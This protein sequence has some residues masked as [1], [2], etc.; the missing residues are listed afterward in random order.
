MKRLLRRYILTIFCLWVVTRVFPSA[1]QFETGLDTGLLLASLVIM[2]LDLILK[3]IINLILL[4]FNFLTLGAFRWVALVA[5]FWLADYLLPGF[6]INAFTIPAFTV[7]TVSI[8]EITLSGLWAYVGIG[9]FI[10]I[11]MSLILWLFK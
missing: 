2:T 11:L 6:S 5:V 7:Y 9:F 1:L 10:D 8:P 4:P 3:P